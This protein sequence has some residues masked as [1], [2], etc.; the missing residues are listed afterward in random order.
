MV[1]DAGVGIISR[2]IEN[3]LDNVISRNI[4]FEPNTFG[5]SYE[6]DRAYILFMP[7]RATDNSATQAFR[8]NIFER[9]WSRWIYSAKCGIVMTRDRSIYLGDTAI[10]NVSKE[11]KTGQ[12]TDF[13][14]KTLTNSITPAGYFRTVLTLSNLV[15]IEPNDVIVQEQP[16]TVNYFNSRLLHKMDLF[17]TGINGPS[18]A[19]MVDSFKAK[20]GDSMVAKMQTLNNY[21]FT[22]DAIN[23]TE[24]TF[25]S[26]NIKELTELL[27][28]ELNFPDT[29][30]TVK[31]YKKPDTTVYETFITLLDKV[32]NQIT[33]YHERPFIEGN[34]Q[35]F[36][37]IYKEIEWN[38][39]HFGDP[40]ALKQVRH[41]TIIFDQNNFYNRYRYRHGQNPGN[42]G[43]DAGSAGGR[44]TGLRHEAGGQRL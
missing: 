7:G 29:I 10:N 19:T 41:A 15:N 16:V 5:I 22:L 17:D 23:I 12:R 34:L 18:G 1:T 11:R 26:E 44:E 3:L 35:V 43:F 42:G 32:R 28:D 38:P 37:G 2:G 8:Y 9:T 20:P 27:V 6:N 40:S 31:S 24:K 21:L 4:D 33:V 30:S 13:A 36:K 39:Q 25:T 14:E